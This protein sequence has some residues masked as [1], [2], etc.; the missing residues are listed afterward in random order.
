MRGRIPHTDEYSSGCGQDFQMHQ[1]SPASRALVCSSQTPCRRMSWPWWSLACLS[2]GPRAVKSNGVGVHVSAVSEV[3]QEP[4]AG[5]RLL[6]ITS[7]AVRGSLTT[8]HVSRLA[9]RLCVERKIR[10]AYRRMISSSKGTRAAA[11][12]PARPGT[13]RVL[14]ETTHL[15]T[16]KNPVTSRF[17]VPGGCRSLLNDVPGEARDL[18]CQGRVDPRSSTNCWA[19]PRLG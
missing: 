14:A 9:L 17:G 4:L 8:F 12:L 19:E 7:V 1:S 13:K 11:K 6:S 15:R 10:S 16:R 3:L 5:L 2:R 18:T